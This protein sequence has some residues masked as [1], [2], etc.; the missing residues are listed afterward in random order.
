[1][2][3]LVDDEEDGTTAEE[4]EEAVGTSVACMQVD[5]VSPLINSI[6]SSQKYSL[7]IELVKIV[8]KLWYK[9]INP[10]QR[11]DCRPIIA[12][13]REFTMTVVI[14]L[15]LKFSGLRDQ[16]ITVDN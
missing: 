1:M 12:L 7:V 13:Y 10:W 8:V 15:G 9:I 2:A 14:T 16:V 3:A 4:L 6:I 5:M 11:Q